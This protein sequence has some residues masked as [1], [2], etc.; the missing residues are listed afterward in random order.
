MI[1]KTHMAFANVVSLP[2]A[3]TLIKTGH[4]TTLLSFV[5]FMC[6]VSFAS[7]FPDID[8]RGSKLSQNFP[9]NIL[10]F[11]LTLFVK[12]R[13]FT[14]NFCGIF[15]LALLPLI[16]GLIA[17]PLNL[18]IIYILPWTLGYILHI[19]G[20][21]MTISGVVNF[22]CGKWFGMKKQFK[23]YSIPKFLRFRTFS[24]KETIF[25]FIFMIAMI[26]YILYE[27]KMGTFS[28]LIKNPI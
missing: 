6:I 25:Y 4:I 7:L 5:T 14:H 17:L 11:F 24:M 19:L 1:Y 26:F 28:E 8:E 3:T 10:S 12:H 22:F 2:I 21:A 13:G 15:F 27:I 23:L 20:D 9:F 16:V 18:A